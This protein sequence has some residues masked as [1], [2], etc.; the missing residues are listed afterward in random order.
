MSTSTGGTPFKKFEFDRR[1]L[2]GAALHETVTENF[3][4]PSE[5]A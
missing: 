2:V 1:L 5:T 3:S 4:A